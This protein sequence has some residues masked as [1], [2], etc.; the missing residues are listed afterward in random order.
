MSR[1]V[2]QVQYVFLALVHILHL[3]GMTFDGDATLFL[4]IHVVKHLTF[5]HLNGFGIFKHTV[6][7]RRL[8]VVDVSDDTEVSDMFHEFVYIQSNAKLRKK[9]E[10]PAY[11]SDFILVILQK[12][13]TSNL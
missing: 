7:K 8:S 11:L 5:S 12:L 13:Q 3:D 4:Q 1:G 10:I 6:S 9:I 2:N